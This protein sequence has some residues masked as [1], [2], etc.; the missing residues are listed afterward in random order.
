MDF[1]LNEE[2]QMLADTVERWL[3]SNYDFAVPAASCARRLRASRMRT[4]P[5]LA[6]LGLLGL[7]VPAEHGGL[8]AG[9]SET[10]IVMRAFGRALLAE[11]YLPTAVMAVEGLKAAGTPAQQSH[12]LPRIVSGELR[13]ALALLEPGARYDLAAVDT[14]ATA[15]ADDVESGYV[16]QGRKG[17][18]LQGAAAQ[19][20]I[21]SAHLGGHCRDA[22]W[23]G[24]VHRRCCRSRSAAAFLPD[25]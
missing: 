8:G 5:Q 20:L 14:T 2:Q 13:F 22:S 12:F 18:V 24:A 11:P 7:N 17:V 10:L 4:G 16:L 25:D 6:D 19:R 15:L 3:A 21:V 23:R 1:E 9:A